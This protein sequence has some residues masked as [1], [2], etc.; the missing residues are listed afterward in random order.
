[1]AAVE[2]P[3]GAPLRCSTWT[4]ENG[5]DPIGT[6]GSYRAFLMVE[7]PLPWPRDMGD[8]PALGS[9]RPALKAARARLQGLA[10][11]GRQAGRG[12]PGAG[13]RRRL[14]LYQAEE[15]APGSFV[16]YRRREME[17][18]AE[19]V[20]AAAEA[21]LAGDGGEADQADG[22]GAEVLIC[23]HGSRDR[24]CGSLGTSLAVPLLGAPDLLAPG[25]RV[26]RTSHTGGHRFAPTAMVF[27]SGT[28]WGYTSAEDL[29]RVVT[30]GRL[31][32]DLLSRYRGCAGLGSPRIQALEREVLAEVG[33]DL[34]DC[35]RQGSQD[36]DR[37]TLEVGGT[38]GGT[39]EATVEV[40]RSLPVPQ[41]GAPIEEASK[42]E[43][44]L[45]VR[46][47]RRVG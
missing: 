27:P 29:R 17:V 36:G 14:M 34:F 44:E 15:Q 46:D 21:L 13:E 16:R 5:V 23:G 9:L 40:G 1:M 37:V 43:S 11:A 19:E 4:R 12:S 32:R 39:W 8:I 31:D 6:A 18:P 26:W 41:C 3:S 24:C 28:G 33:W 38:V 2:S 20:A 7:W 25:T 35:P 30:R 47:A 42:T 22:V 10:A 45:A